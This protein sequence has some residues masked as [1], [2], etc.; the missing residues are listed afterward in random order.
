MWLENKG[1]PTVT[2]VTVPFHEPARLTATS[3]GLPNLPLIV[4]P[5]PI[6]HL[7]ENEVQALAEAAYPKIVEALTQTGNGATDFFVDYQL[8][9]GRTSLEDCEVCVE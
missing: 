7:P 4:L 5:H 3:M 1:I 6:G 9:E 8:P 2:V